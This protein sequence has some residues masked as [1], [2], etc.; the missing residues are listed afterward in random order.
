MLLNYVAGEDFWQSFG[1][2][3]DQTSQSQRKSTLHIHWKDRCWSW[4]SSP[5]ATWCKELTHWKRSWCWKRLRAG[6]EGGS[7]GWDGWMASPT[8]WTWVWTNL[9]RLWRTGNP[10]VLQFM[11]SQRLGHNWVT[12][13]YLYIHVH[14]IGDAIQPSHPLLP[15]TFAFNL[16]QHQ[17]L[18][19]WVCS[20][21]QIAKV[22]ELQLQHQSFQWIFRVDFL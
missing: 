6:G 10:S 21:H 13:T 19:Q 7:R 14:W 3:G 2:Q 20:L 15:P 17:S 16:S 9:G 12:F 4:S 5:W 8:Q 22:L 11:G 1:L 18:F